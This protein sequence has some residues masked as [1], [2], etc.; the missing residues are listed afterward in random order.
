MGYSDHV[1]KC[2]DSVD[3]GCGSTLLDSYV[4]IYDTDPL[5]AD[6]ALRIASTNELT[7]RVDGEENGILT[8][9]LKVIWYYLIN[10]LSD[11]NAS[12][13]LGIWYY[14]DI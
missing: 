2:Q 11:T 12:Y 5:M 13:V 14:F 7:F 8:T 3:D 9:P 1:I 10:I 4:S 6:N